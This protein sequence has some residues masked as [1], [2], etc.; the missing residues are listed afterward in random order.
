MLRETAVIK[1]LLPLAIHHDALQD[2]WTMNVNAAALFP[3]WDGFARSLHHFLRVDNL[4]HIKYHSGAF[5]RET[6]KG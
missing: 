6:G 2:L 1:V 4:W 5:A 3:G